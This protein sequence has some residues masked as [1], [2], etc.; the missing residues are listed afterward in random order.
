MKKFFVLFLFAF[1]MVGCFSGKFL[2]IGP[3]VSICDG[4][5]ENSLICE[6]FPRPE[7]QDLLLRLVNFELMKFEVFDPDQVDNFFTEIEERLNQGGITYSMVYQI[8]SDAIHE[9]KEYAGG[10]I[11]IFAEYAGIFQQEIT[12]ISDFDRQLLLKH[13]ENQRST[14]RLYLLLEG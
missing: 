3:E 13:I 1:L 4:A 14:I 12:L 2:R 6:H 9:I 8:A 7:N 5:P 10:E 11:L